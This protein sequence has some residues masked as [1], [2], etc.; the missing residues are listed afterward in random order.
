ME[1]IRGKRMLPGRVELPQHM[2]ARFAA[3][4]NAGIST[5]GQLMRRLGSSSRMIEFSAE[6]GLTMD[7]LVLLKREAGSCLSRP[8]PLSAFPG[9]PYEYA[10]ALKS[11]GY[12]NTRDFFEK[13]Q[14]PDQKILLS[15]E[16]G[17]PL[18][19][20]KELYALCDLSRIAGVGGVFARVIYETGIRSSGEFALTNATEHYPKYNKVIDTY[21]YAMGHVS[22]E[23][24]RY[25][26]AY[27]GL[28]A[29]ADLH[30]EE[31]P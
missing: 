12:A 4:R 23:D 14:T 13:T 20:L 26:M 8:F 29:R 25:C 31:G 6:S 10:E 19:R 17:I 5:L 15:G 3:L 7:Y 16:T 2:D 24:V 1:L 9:I 28:F 11:K 18:A 30:T 22:E 27:A 21:A